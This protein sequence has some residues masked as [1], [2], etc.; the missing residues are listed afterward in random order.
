MMVCQDN[1]KS[2]DGADDEATRCW[3]RRRPLA[4][5]ETSP[6]ARPFRANRGRVE[7]TD[8]KKRGNGA[9]AGKRSC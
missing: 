9:H 4:V 2:A 7:G 3:S 6:P 1:Q 8:G 5:M